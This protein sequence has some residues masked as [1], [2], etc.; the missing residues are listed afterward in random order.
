MTEKKEDKV[1]VFI[2]AA[3]YYYAER[4]LGWQINYLKFAD[5]FKSK[6]NVAKMFFYK[7]VQTEKMF[8]IN[9]PQGSLADFYKQRQKKRS[10]FKHL[11]SLGVTV[12]TKPVHSMYDKRSGSWIYKCNFDVELTIDALDSIEEYDKALLCT[13]DGD[14]AQLVKYLKGKF[15]KV[16]VISARDRCSTFLKEAKPH[17]IIWLDKLKS[18]ISWQ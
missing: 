13:G 17:Q 15:K 8:L 4:A 10:F 2:D 11:R 16:Y 7:G 9:N 12:R 5:Y 6:F 14:F 3:N 18:H 1:A